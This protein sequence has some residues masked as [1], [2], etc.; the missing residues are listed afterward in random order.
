M[1]YDYDVIIVG[2]GPGG[3]S[4]ARAC[5]REGLRTL[6]LEKDPL[7]RYKPCGGCLPLKCIALLGD[8]LSSVFEN[9]IYRARFTYRLK[10]PFVLQ[11]KAPIAYMVR[12]ERFDHFLV[13]RALDA[14]ATLHEGERVKGVLE[15]EA[16]VEV[17][18]A[19]GVRLTCKSVI[20]A[21]GP[22]SV[23][24]RSLEGTDPPSRGGFAVQAEVPLESVPH[25]PAEDRDAVHLDFGGIPRG[26]GWV[27]PKKEWLSIGIG[28][29]FG[30]NGK[31]N[32]LPYYDRFVEGLPYLSREK[33]SRLTGH[34]LPSFY[35]WNQK[36]A[37]GRR[38]MVGDAARLMDPL[39]GEGIY[40]A[41]RSGLLAAEAIVRSEAT[42]VLPASFYQKAVEVQLF[43]NLRWALRFSRFVFQFTKLCYYTLQRHPEIGD[44]YLRVLDGSESYEE[45]VAHVKQRVK[46]LFKRHL[47][48]R[49]KRAFVDPGSE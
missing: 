19:R 13:R 16:G 15:K 42:G 37:Q 10:D 39:T 41:L 5:A 12:R 20:G 31:L 48:E 27:F 22:R 38:M 7:P 2:A 25:F 24:A 47:S 18:L 29:M 28:G 6:L 43:P 33:V 35:D 40:Y 4:A 45:F 32:P 21:D 34:F 36:V 23:V 11:S 30:E 9:T 26:Y 1:K 46:G 44:V 14:G 49:I 3:S 17:V 8:D